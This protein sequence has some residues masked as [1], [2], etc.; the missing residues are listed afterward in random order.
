MLLSIVRDVLAEHEA[1]RVHDR[2]RS[3]EKN[4]FSQSYDGAYYRGSAT[5]ECRVCEIG[6]N[7]WVAQRLIDFYQRE[8]AAR[9]CRANSRLVPRSEKH[10]GKNE[11]AARGMDGLLDKSLRSENLSG[12]IVEFLSCRAPKQV[13]RDQT[14]H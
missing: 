4:H 13:D 7:L 14:L 3:S 11:E 8:P 10:R 6:M 5:G 1:H 2:P 9:Y 12:T